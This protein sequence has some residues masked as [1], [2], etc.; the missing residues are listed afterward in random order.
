MRVRFLSAAGET[1]REVDATPG[2]RLLKLAQHWSMPLEGSCGGHM[3]CSTCH[4]ILAPD[5]ADLL[6]DPIE[7]EEDMLDFAPGATR[8][9]RLACQVWLPQG[10]D[11][12]D[13]RMPPSAQ[14]ARG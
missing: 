10:V 2:M 1:L 9:S 6:P 13:V 7:A 8:T 12:F 3:A 5:Q 14:D 11:R 4:V